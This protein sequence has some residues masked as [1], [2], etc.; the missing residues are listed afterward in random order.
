MQL[1]D[2]LFLLL[3]ADDVIN[4]E[5]YYYYELVSDRINCILDSCIMVYRTF[6]CGI[7][8]YCILDSLEVRHSQ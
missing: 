4:L 1:S 5:Y 7:L 2:Y 8:Y 6:D 3:S